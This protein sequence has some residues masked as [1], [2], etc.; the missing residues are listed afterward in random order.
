[1]G[2]HD[3]LSFCCTALAMVA[4]CVLLMI[5]CMHGN[6]FLHFVLQMNTVTLH[7]SIWCCPA[8]SL[9]LPPHIMQPLWRGNPALF[10]TACSQGCSRK[11]RRYSGP[12][13][14]M[15]FLG[16]MT[17]LCRRLFSQP[18]MR[19]PQDS[20]LF[21]QGF[22]N[23]RHVPLGHCVAQANVQWVIPKPFLRVQQLLLH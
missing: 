3:K 21:L 6:G 16:P 17:L 2:F 13:T 5:F 20:C 11:P 12:K 8:V 9:E 15:S 10:D 14:Q 19:L 7:S 23:S 4:E 18:P 22:C 1:M